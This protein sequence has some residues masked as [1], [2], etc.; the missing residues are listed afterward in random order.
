MTVRVVRVARLID[1][2]I[3][4]NGTEANRVID[5]RFVFTREIICASVAPTSKLRL[6]PTPAVLI[7]T[8]QQAVRIG[9][10]RG[11]ASA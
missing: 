9:R 7:I 6:C 8:D 3:F 5:D 10:Q 11:L 4:D 2:N 1:D